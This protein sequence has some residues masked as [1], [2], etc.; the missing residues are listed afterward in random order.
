MND[1][2]HREV[3]ASRQNKAVRGVQE[4]RYTRK[5]ST[6]VRGK[7][8]NIKLYWTFCWASEVRRSEM[9]DSCSVDC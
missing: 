8:E 7:M 4:G 9:S 5:G 2:E 3:T 6:A 1:V